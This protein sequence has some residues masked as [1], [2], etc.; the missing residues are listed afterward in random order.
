MGKDKNNWREKMYAGVDPDIRQIVRILDQNGV[1]TYESCAASGP[2]GKG[3]PTN[4]KHA[5][6]EPTVAF[7]GNDAA[8]LHALAIAIDHGLPVRD[9]HRTWSVS[10]HREITG[11]TWKMTFDLSLRKLTGWLAPDCKVYKN[12]RR[13]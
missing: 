5:Y 3:Y 1:E 11:P 8:G 7:H 6:A 10:G 4:S 2:H 13:V 12:E 9:L